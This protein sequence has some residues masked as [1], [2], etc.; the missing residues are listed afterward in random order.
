MKG[1]GCEAAVAC[2]PSI[3]AS[4]KIDDPFGSVLDLNGSKMEACRAHQ[5]EVTRDTCLPTLQSQS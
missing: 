4:A 1:C 5:R 2:Q 3:L